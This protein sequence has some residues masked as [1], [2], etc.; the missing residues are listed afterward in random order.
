ML[1]FTSTSNFVLW[2]LFWL[3]CW[4]WSCEVGT[5]WGRDRDRV[6]RSGVGTTWGDRDGVKRSGVG[7]FGGDRDGVKTSGVLSLS[8]ASFTLMSALPSMKIS[9]CSSSFTPH[10]FR[11]FDTELC[12]VHKV[13]GHCGSICLANHNHT[14]PPRTHTNFSH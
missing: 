10:F 9:L 4:E 12:I 8:L 6:K 7:P 3:L 11:S 2:S 14:P 13:N 5:T 1:F